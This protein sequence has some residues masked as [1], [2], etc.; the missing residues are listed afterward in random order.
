MLANANDKLY[1]QVKR[2]SPM[3][4]EDWEL[5]VPHIERHSLDKGA[6]FVEPGKRAP[7]VAFVLSGAFRQYYLVEGEERSTYFYFEGD[8]LCDYLG[9]LRGQASRLGISVL[10]Q[11]D[12]LQFPYAIVEKLYSASGAW[13]SFGRKLAEYLAAGLEDRMVSLLTLKPEQRYEALLQSNKRRILERV[14]QQDIASYLGITPVSLSRI[15][16]RFRN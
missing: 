2:F 1:E 4:V 14:P 11:A 8:L 7:Y 13:N 15:R 12:I 6:L 9:C 3:P 10:E 5:L 16:S